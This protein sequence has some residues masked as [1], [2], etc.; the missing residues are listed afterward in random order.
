MR[1]EGVLSM[2]EVGSPI[3]DIVTCSS[4]SFHAVHRSCHVSHALNF[5]GKLL[6]SMSLKLSPLKTAKTAVCP[7]ESCGAHHLT[8]APNL[9]R[10]RPLQSG[11]RGATT[12]LLSNLT[13]YTKPALKIL[14][15]RTLWVANRQ[16]SRSTSTS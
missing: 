4:V 11:F 10:L 3:Q 2:V 14:Y 16:T 6:M 13:T 15:R 5:G 8:P 9:L 7:Y 12:F 1:A